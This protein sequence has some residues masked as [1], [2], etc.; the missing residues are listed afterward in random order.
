MPLIKIED[1]SLTYEAERSRFQALEHI[2]LDIEKGEFVCIIGPSGCGKS[3]LLGVL[4]GLLEPSSGA[5]YINDKKIHGAGPER[6]VVFQ[7]Y[8]LFPWMS[9][10]RN[11]AFAVRESKSGVKKIKKSESYR[12]AD[13]YLEK[14]GLAEYG[15]KKPG[16]LSGG[17]QQRVAIAR[18]LACDPEILLMDE[19]FGAIDAKTRDV[20]QHLLLKL[21]SEDKEKKTIVFVTH[22]L[23]EAI[24]LADRI[25]FMEPKGV[26]SVIDV[27]L[28]R[29]RDKEKLLSNETY[30]T[31]RMKL[32]K[33]FSKESE[34]QEL[35]GGA[36]I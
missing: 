4:E 15:H 20:L 12:I 1:L 31:L 7:N 29:P 11:V 26:K 32:V 25:V 17:M 18:A 19:P 30:R 9:A 21:W 13:E 34:E 2:N 33:L 22:D 24:F 10:R 27:D 6:A 36:G 28:E 14:V 5:V 3:T 23:E 8:S 35:L 16:E